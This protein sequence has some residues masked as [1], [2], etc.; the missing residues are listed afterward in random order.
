[1]EPETM[2]QKKEP[3]SRNGRIKEIVKENLI[4]IMMVLALAIGV[5]VGLGVRQLDGWEYYQKRKLFYLRFPGDL[6]MNMLK[7]LILP[8]IVSS[9]ISSLAS[10]NAKASGLVLN[11]FP[12]VT[13]YYRSWRFTPFPTMFLPLP[14]NSSLERYLIVV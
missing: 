1:M 3:R 7:M 13:E 12:H 5:A 14:K 4:I 2:E 6:L 11:P 10:L 9:I 8:L